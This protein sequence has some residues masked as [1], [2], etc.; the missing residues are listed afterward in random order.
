[1]IVMIFV[2]KDTHEWYTASVNL[3]LICVDLCRCFVLKNKVVGI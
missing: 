3:L 1:M 2:N